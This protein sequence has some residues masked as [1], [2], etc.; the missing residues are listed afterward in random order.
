[1]KPQVVLSCS[2]CHTVLP[3]F[4]MIVGA[5]R[6]TMNI[7]LEVLEQSFHFTR[8]PTFKISK[9][10][11]GLAKVEEASLHSGVVEVVLNGRDKVCF[12]IANKF[13]RIEV[14]RQVLPLWKGALQISGYTWED[15]SQQSS[16]IRRSHPRTSSYSEPAAS[17]QVQGQKSI[18]HWSANNI[19]NIAR[20]SL[21]LFVWQELQLIAQLPISVGIS[22]PDGCTLCAAP[23]P[24]LDNARQCLNGWRNCLPAHCIFPSPVSY[25]LRPAVSTRQAAGDDKMREGLPGS[26]PHAHLNE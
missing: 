24:T 2:F 1:M 4:Q 12:K 18:Y 10:A 16:N 8:L 25:F 13:C 15:L 17:H 11:A 22:W 5:H 19:F 20:R 23:G 7:P 26:F 6:Y 3:T 9:P 14:G 21:L